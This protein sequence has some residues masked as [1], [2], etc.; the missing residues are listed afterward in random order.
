M[1]RLDDMANIN[2]Y[3]RFLAGQQTRSESNSIFS[4]N[5]D[6]IVQIKFGKVYSKKTGEQIPNAKFITNAGYGE[7]V[8]YKV[9]NRI[10][11][12]AKN[13]TSKTW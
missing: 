5:R 2:Q 6:E 11:V 3:K 7:G 13:R 8:A 9:G 12:D 1:T 10:I 4:A